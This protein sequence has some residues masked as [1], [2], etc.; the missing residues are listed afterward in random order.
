MLKKFKHS[1]V[2]KNRYDRE[3][4]YFSSINMSGCRHRG[5]YVPIWV[6]EFSVC[7]SAAVHSRY[8]R[9]KMVHLPNESGSS[10]FHEVLKGKYLHLHQ[11]NSQTE[12]SC[13]IY[14][15][16]KVCVS[17]GGGGY[18]HCLSNEGATSMPW[19]SLTSTES[20]GDIWEDKSTFLR[21]R[22]VL[23]IL[24]KKDYDYQKHFPSWKDKNKNRSVE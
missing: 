17:G 8:M 4:Y 9:Y 11:F 19:P 6:V 22:F 5:V 2:C 18:I 20:Q 3:I 14:T 7:L 12:H 13:D 16:K 23:S 1:N 21:Q 24:L 15:E 10:R